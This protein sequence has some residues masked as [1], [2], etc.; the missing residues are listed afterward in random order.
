MNTSMYLNFIRK[1]IKTDGIHVADIANKL[2]LE[3]KRITLDQ[4]R[5]ASAILVE[6]YLAQ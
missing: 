3:M 1:A 4:Y 6:A 5:K 2:A